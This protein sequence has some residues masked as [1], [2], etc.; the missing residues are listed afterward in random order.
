MRVVEQVYN[1]AALV[2]PSDTVDIAVTKGLMIGGTGALAVIMSSG[3]QLIITGLAVGVI[4][5]MA[6]RRVLAAGTAATNIVAFS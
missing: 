5:Q 3:Q 6:V 1:S 4:H 2:T